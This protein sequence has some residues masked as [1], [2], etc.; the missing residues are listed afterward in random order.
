MK[1]ALVLAYGLLSYSIFFGLFLYLVGFLANAVVPVTID[2]GD[3]KPL[4][5]AL[6]VNIGWILLFGLQHSIM[7]RPGFKEVWTKIIPAEIERSTYVLASSLALAPMI[8]FWV[9]MPTV[10]WDV[11]GGPLE[12]VAWGGFA[13]GWLCLLLSTF[14]INHFD[15]FGLSQV[16]NHAR[17]VESKSLQFSVRAFYKFT[18]HP[19]YVGW[20]I[21]VWSTPYM[22]LGHLLFAGGLTVYI[23]VAVPLEERDLIA[24]HGDKYRR[25]KETTPML[26][27]RLSRTEHPVTANEAA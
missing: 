22:T 3:A 2:S 23:L 27:P 17:G 8:F 14:M 13:L 6:L 7:A 1:K 10:L 25:Y 20:I 16:V 5:V 24:E 15:L 26:I 21:A 11:T 19:I 12:M 4:G 9:P 18:R